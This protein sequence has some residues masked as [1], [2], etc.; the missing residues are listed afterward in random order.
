MSLKSMEEVEAFLTAHDRVIL[1]CTTHTCNVCLSIEARFDKDRAIYEK[2]PV[3]KVYVDDLA[4]F[5]GEHSVFAVP[6]VLM[7]F[8]QKEIYRTSRFIEFARLEYFVEMVG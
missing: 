3:K 6:T 5:R 1:L 8:E 4:L 2:W 7:F